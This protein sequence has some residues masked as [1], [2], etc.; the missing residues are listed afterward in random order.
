MLK[1][2]TLSAS[3]LALLL[4]L[5]AAA[6][7][8]TTEEAPAPEATAPEAAPAE[9]ETAV[10][11]GEAT[12]AQATDSEAAVPAEPATPVTRDTVV[13]SDRHEVHIA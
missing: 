3:A 12:D 8:T 10:P 1:Q 7:E 2:L 6:Q 5:P 9:G 4:A 13:A 11:D